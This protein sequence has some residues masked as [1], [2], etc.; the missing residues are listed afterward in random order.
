MNIKILNR[1]L[2]LSW[3]LI[4]TGACILNIGAGLIV[5][6]IFLVFITLFMA[7]FAGVYVSKP[8]TETEAY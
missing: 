8:E 6:G 5:S 1:Y 3:V 4:T 2:A 7:R